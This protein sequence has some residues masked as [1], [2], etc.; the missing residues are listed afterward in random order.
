MIFQ[1][2]CAVSVSKIHVDIDHYRTTKGPSTLNEHR[3]RLSAEMFYSPYSH[4]SI[5]TK[6]PKQQQQKQ[7]HHQ[8]QQQQQNSENAFSTIVLLKI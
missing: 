4:V 1:L 3:G 2:Y 5:R 6:I 8:Q 7:Q